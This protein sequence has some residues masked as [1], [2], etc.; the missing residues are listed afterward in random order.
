MNKI[1]EMM[2]LWDS[3][4]ESH[5]FDTSLSFDNLMTWFRFLNGHWSEGIPDNDGQYAISFEEPKEKAKIY[6]SL[7]ARRFGDF[8][9]SN[10]S[11]YVIDEEDEV[12]HW[13]EP[14]PLMPHIKE[15]N[16]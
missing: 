9:V 1:N 12:W 7:I 4:V 5:D 16:G 6:P 15:D 3:Y 2:V 13:S 10:E 14:L 11:G 8:F